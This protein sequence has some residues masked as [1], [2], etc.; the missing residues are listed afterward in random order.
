MIM[1]Q[2]ATGKDMALSLLLIVNPKIYNQGFCK[3]KI[4]VLSFQIHHWC[5]SFPSLTILVLLWFSFISLVFFY[6][7]KLIF[8]GFLQVL[9]MV[10][11]KIP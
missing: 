5:Q 3:L 2:V 11:I 10:K 8:S 9:S 6:L 4:L 1:V 7:S